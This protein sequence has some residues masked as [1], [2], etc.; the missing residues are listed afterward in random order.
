MSFLQ[1]EAQRARAYFPRGL[2]QP[3][4]AFRFAQDALLL[5]AFAA[6]LCPG[7]RRLADLG[8][9]VGPVALAALLLAG[10]EG[11]KDGRAAWGLDKE[12]ELLRAAAANAARLGFGEA[13]KPVQA[14]FLQYRPGALAGSFDLI[15]ANPPYRLPGAGRLPQARLRRE[16]LFAG[17][18]NLAA[19]VRAGSELLAP[20]GL[21]CLVFPTARAD[22]LMVLLH[23]AGLALAEALPVAVRDGEEPALLLVAAGVGQ[24]NALAWRGR[25]PLILYAAKARGGESLSAEALDFCPFLAS[26][27]K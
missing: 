7:W 18:E 12:S 22:E 20:G 13:F 21:F 16:A 2:E 8:C 15:T 5:A 17:P 4:G 24:N 26:N 1:P 6:R 14:D 9:G 23:G 27:A 11:G 19:F 25:Q 10:D 3:A